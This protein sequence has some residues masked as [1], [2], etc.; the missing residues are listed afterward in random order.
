MQ[1]LA[2]IVDFDGVYLVAGGIF[3]P[4][5]TVWIP[6]PTSWILD[7]NLRISDS[8]TVVESGFQLAYCKVDKYRNTHFHFQV[9][10]LYIIK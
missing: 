5:P 10:L 4:D 8:E 6:D 1:S 2:A 7:F 3:I 9:N